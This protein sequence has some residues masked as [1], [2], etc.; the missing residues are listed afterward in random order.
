MSSSSEG[1]S[2]MEQVESLLSVITF[3][4]KS[5]NPGQVDDMDIEL[6]KSFSISHLVIAENLRSLN[7]NMNASNLK[8]K[9][10]D[11]SGVDNNVLEELIV[12]Q[13]NHNNEVDADK[14]FD[15]HDAPK[16]FALDIKQENNDQVDDFE[17]SNEN[18]LDQIEFDHKEMNSEETE[19][20][21]EAFSENNDNLNQ[22][23]KR[24]YKK[25]IEVQLIVFRCLFCDLDFRE[26]EDFHNHDSEKHFKGGKF[27]CVCNEGFSDKRDA[28]HHFMAE[29][30]KKNYYTLNHEI[31]TVDVFRCLFCK[32]DFREEV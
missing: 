10:A 6:L 4:L 17:C 3:V 20:L 30:K 28:V 21:K 25:G 14:R 29:H 27:H 22:Q 18:E 16:S 26:E 9:A 23:K 12:L 1:S 13:E 15:S 24:K 2:K 19:V 11:E 8:A 5:I 31:E 7:D 32:L